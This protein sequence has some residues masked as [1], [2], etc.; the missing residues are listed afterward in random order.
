MNN[1]ETKDQTQE[2]DVVAELENA[3]EQLSFEYIL[4]IM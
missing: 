1:E 4:S 3:L 2:N